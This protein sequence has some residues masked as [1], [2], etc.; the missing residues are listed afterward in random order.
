MIHVDIT[1]HSVFMYLL[2]VVRCK[3]T[4]LDTELRHRVHCI[5]IYSEVHL[6]GCRFFA[7]TPLH[8]SL[9][10][11]TPFHCNASFPYQS[12][13]L[14]SCKNGRKIDQLKQQK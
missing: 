5:T 14:N 8:L 1:D 3:W 4:S 2:L 13:G 6:P 11:R 12:F 7:L 9:R 10:R